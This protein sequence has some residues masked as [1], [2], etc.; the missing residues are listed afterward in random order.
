M[1]FGPVGGVHL[2]DVGVG[3]F[4]LAVG[5]GLGG[6]ESASP[7]VG[8]AGGGRQ[9]GLADVPDGQQL[10]G[11]ADS[12]GLQVSGGLEFFGGYRGVGVHGGYLRFCD[13][14]RG[15]SF[16]GFCRHSL[17]GLG[18]AGRAYPSEAGA[19]PGQAQR[20][21]AQCDS[22]HQVAPPGDRGG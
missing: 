9:C 18:G 19:Y 22:Q 11:A 15:V 8:G 4:G 3:F 7:L 20:L 14:G 12:G 1:V 2:V 16:G 10:V 6:G 21:D 17:R 5:E 13:S